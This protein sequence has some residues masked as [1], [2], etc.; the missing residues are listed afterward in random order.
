MR[1]SSQLDGRCGPA[2]PHHWREQAREVLGRPRVTGQCG[3][4]QRCPSIKSEGTVDFLIEKGRV[5][6]IVK[7]SI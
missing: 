4:A 2:R 6:D 5:P 3:P 1:V 7:I